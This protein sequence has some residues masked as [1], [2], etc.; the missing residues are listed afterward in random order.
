[1]YLDLIRPHIGVRHDQWF[2]IDVAI[3]ALK[4][5]KASAWIESFKKINLHPVHRVPF[6]VW[7]K[8]ID[9]TLSGGEFFA[10]RTSLFDA[11]PVMWKS[12]SVEDRHAV[13]QSLT[14]FTMIRRWKDK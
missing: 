13:D 1:M 7:L 5:I 14:A 9:S 11:M 2:L 10:S 4:K 3:E 6:D 8:K 12:M